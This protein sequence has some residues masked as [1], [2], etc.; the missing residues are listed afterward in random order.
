MKVFGH[1]H[2]CICMNE[3]EQVCVLNAQST[4]HMTSPAPPSLTN[5][6][7]HHLVNLTT[8]PHNRV[9]VRTQCHLPQ[10]RVHHQ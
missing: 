5:P 3:Y 1:E 7:H 2:A 6:K 4:V 8:R 9:V 10:A